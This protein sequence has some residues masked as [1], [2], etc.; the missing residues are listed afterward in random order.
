MKN[1]R[2]GFIPVLLGI[3]LFFSGCASLNKTQKGAIIGTAAGATIGTI[4]GKTAGNTALGTIIG[5]VV[6]GTAGVIIGRQMDKQAEEIKASVPD[7]EVVRVEEGIMVE[8]SSSVLFGFDKSN[9]SNDAKTNL[10]KLVIVLN[11]YKDTD[12][13]IQGHTDSKGSEAYNQTLSEQR[14]FS[15]S[16]YLVS[17][18]ILSNRVTTKGFGEM[19]PKYVN[20]TVDGRDKNRRVEFLITANETMKAE[21]EKQAGK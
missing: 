19:L 5:A 11:N 8:F 1:F 9:L 20:D 18:G 15:V 16:S 12:I 17:K 6:G 7:V 21:A 3:V 14:A 2:K 4:V 10:D 13:V